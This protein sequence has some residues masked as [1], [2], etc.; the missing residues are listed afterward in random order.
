MM[1]AY[2]Y[3]YPNYNNQYNNYGGGYSNYSYP[4]GNGGGYGCGYPMQD[5]YG[6]MDWQASFAMQS[7]QMQMQMQQQVQQLQMRAQQGRDSE[8]FHGQFT[9]NMEGLDQAQFQILEK[10]L[11][12]EE[13]ID[14]TLEQAQ[15]NKALAKYSADGVLSQQERADLAQRRTK[16]QQKML[17][18]KKGDCKPELGKLDPVARK[19]AELA[20]RLHDMVKGGKLSLEDAKKLRQLMFYAAQYDGVDEANQPYAGPQNQPYAGPQAQLREELTWSLD[21]KG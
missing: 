17:A 16:L 14:L 2:G 15:L 3:S 11:N 6:G 7:Q 19:D 4:G 21:M 13:F 18:Y 1:Q 5:S 8:R 12:R 10:D 9:K 20:G